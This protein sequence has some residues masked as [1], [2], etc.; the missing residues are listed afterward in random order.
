MIV[1]AG[2]I[3]LAIENSGIRE[4][5]EGAVEEADLQEVQTLAQVKW[6]EAY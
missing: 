5:A 4:K 3:I 1:L 2:A 6:A